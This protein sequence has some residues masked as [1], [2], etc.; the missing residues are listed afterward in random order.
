MR[1]EQEQAGLQAHARQRPERS[2]PS[3]RAL[4][5]LTVLVLAVHAALLWQ[6]RSLLPA[7][8]GPGTR[9]AAL[10]LPVFSTRRVEVSAPVAAVGAVARPPRVIR[11]PPRSIPA[12][13]AP[14]PA[15]GD[16][17][18]D[19][20]ATVP[21]SPSD[22][23]ALSASPA[24][25]DP[26]QPQP[27]IGPTS[28]PVAKAPEVSPAAAEH[29]TLSVKVPPP[30]RLSYAVKAEVKHLNYQANG[31]MSWTHDGSQY[32]A[33]ASV[34][35]F[36]IGGRSQTS[37]GRITAAGLAPTRFGDKVRNEQ[38]AHFDAEQGK[39][40]FSANTPDAVLLPGM[41]D[42]LSV[43]MQ[44]ASLVAAEPT[45]FGPGTRIT[46]PTVGPRDAE[47]WVFVVDGPEELALAQGP[48]PTLK[49][50]R[51]P[52]TE[53][54]TRVELWLAPG[55]HYLPARIRIT[56]S[57]GDFVDQQLTGVLTP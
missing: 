22:A 12:P 48:L 41:Q 51:A 26:P 33:Q 40:T 34:K 23:P 3:R 57:Q 52:R 54:D 1:T 25:T 6:G 19:P 16:T 13:Q 15:P 50:T 9:V 46:V 32:E 24:A 30:I 11:R 47:T 53:F 14:S 37:R 43:F 39:V 17:P 10:P 8:E 21:E 36:L 49:I 29:R 55:I 31:E 20:S 5:G 45:Q 38:A 44:L 27:V 28:A 35:M 56:Q 18:P 7:G 4:V 42:R 2:G